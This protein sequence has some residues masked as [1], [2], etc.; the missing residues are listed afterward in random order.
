MNSLDLIYSDSNTNS[1]SNKA[2]YKDIRSKDNS[3]E[4]KKNN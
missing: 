3:N 4:I 1:N 2:S